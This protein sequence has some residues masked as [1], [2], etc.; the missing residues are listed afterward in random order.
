MLHAGPDNFGNVPV[1]DVAT[2]P[3]AYTPNSAGA[4]TATQNTGNAGNRIACGVIVR[5]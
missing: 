3:N 5:A 4:T 1:D 2:A